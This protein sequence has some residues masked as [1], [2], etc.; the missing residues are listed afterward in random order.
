M[1]FLRETYKPGPDKLAYAA[2]DPNATSVVTRV[3]G[4]RH[5][6]THS[7]ITPLSLYKL[8]DGVFALD[9]D[10]RELGNYIFVVEE[11]GKIQTILNAKVYA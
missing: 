6:A 5:S 7:D 9:F 3:Y 10:F 2:I 8:E 4:P 11:D 1:K